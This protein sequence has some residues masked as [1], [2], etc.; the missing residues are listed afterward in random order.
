MPDF[1]GFDGKDVTPGLPIESNAVQS[2]CALNSV[3]SLEKLD[4]LIYPN[5]AV[6]WLNIDTTEEVKH[7][8][9]I[10]STGRRVKQL[11]SLTVPAI[12]MSDLTA[13]V[14]YLKLTVKGGDTITSRIVKL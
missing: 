7:I 10:S 2:F 12:D 3:A 13:G 9:L 5:P 14:Y 8:V 1:E 11:Q 6:D 4:F